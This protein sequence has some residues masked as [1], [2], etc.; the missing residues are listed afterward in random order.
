MKQETGMK[1]AKVGLDSKMLQLQY[2]RRSLKKKNRERGDR[3]HRETFSY[4]EWSYG[5]MHIPIGDSSSLCELGIKQKMVFASNI[6]REVQ[7]NLPE[8]R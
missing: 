7:R 4:M 3:D 2:L 8:S 1:V 5:K 6:T